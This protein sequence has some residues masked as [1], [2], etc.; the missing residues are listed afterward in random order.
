MS[1]FSLKID[2]TLVDILPIDIGLEA[3]YRFQHFKVDQDD[4]S[5]LNTVLDLDFKGIFAGVVL[6]F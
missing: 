3:G 5:D 6:R 4:V 2:Y 1:D